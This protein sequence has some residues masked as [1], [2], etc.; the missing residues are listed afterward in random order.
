MM[1]GMAFSE[2]VYSWVPVN[3]DEFALTD[4][5]FDT[6]KLHVHG[7]GTFLLYSIIGQAWSCGVAGLHVCWWL[8]MAKLVE[9]DT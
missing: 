5:V 7:L 6:V 2:V 3:N 1:F 9:G 8:Q 4:A